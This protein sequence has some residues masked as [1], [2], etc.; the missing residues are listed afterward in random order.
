MYF[1][2]IWIATRP[3]FRN[4]DSQPMPKYRANAKTQKRK[5][6]KKWASGNLAKSENAKSRRKL[7]AADQE[8]KERLALVGAV[9]QNAPKLG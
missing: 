9:F 7:G 8:N 5:K 3:A 2:N 1:R 6:A 4:L